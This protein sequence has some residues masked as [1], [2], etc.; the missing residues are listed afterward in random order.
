MFPKALPSKVVIGLVSQK[1]ANGDYTANPFNFQH[2]NVTNVSMKKNGVEVVWVSIECL[3]F[4]INRN[5]TVAY[6]R[7]FEISDKWLK[8]MGLNISLADFGKGYTCIVFS[9]DPCDFQ[10]LRLPEFSET[11]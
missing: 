7:L 9:L 5:Y 4:G 10:E 3:D 8:D 2:F 1:A 11:R 6:V